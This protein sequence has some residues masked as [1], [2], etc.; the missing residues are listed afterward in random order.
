MDLD[1]IKKKAADLVDE[2]GDKIKDGI[3]K[4]ADV[5][6]DKTSGKHSD[7]IESAAEK[8]KDAVDKLAGGTDPAP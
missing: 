3:D 6:D 2:H 7:K 8:A 5:A 1:D 4:V